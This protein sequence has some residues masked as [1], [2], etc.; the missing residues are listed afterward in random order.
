VLTV[1]VVPAVDSAGFFVAL[2]Q[3]L[4]TGQVI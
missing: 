4:V 1:A 3:G 2:D